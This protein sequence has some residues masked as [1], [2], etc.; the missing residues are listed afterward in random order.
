MFAEHIDVLHNEGATTGWGFG[1]QDP[2]NFDWP[3]ILDS[4]FH[5]GR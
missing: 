2:Q 5:G 1:G 4:F 3:P